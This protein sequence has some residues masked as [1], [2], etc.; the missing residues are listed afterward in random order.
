MRLPSTLAL[1][2]VQPLRSLARNTL[3]SVLAALSIMIGIGAVVC[4]VAI[5]RSGSRRAERALQNLGSDFVWIEA[6]SRAPNGVRTGSHGTT[7][8]TLDDARAIGRDLPL[9][10]RVSP[11]VDGR[12]Q[13][14]YGNRNWNT[15]WRGINQDYFEIRNWNVD[16]GSAFLE[17]DVLRGRSIVLLG[18]TVREKLFGTDDP[19]GKVVR[20]N[21]QLFE[22]TGLLARKGQ[23][24]TGQ[25]QDDNLIVPWTTGVHKLRGRRAEWLDDILCS[26]VSPQAVPPAGSGQESGWGSGSGSNCC[27]VLE[28]CR[29]RSRSRSRVRRFSSIGTSLRAPEPAWPQTP[30]ASP[31][32]RSGARVCRHR[33]AS[34]PPPPRPA[35]RGSALRPTPARPRCRSAR[36]GARGRDGRGAPPRP[37]R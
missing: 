34:S 21:E 24:A 9:I 19:L 17:D 32:K 36:R 29:S 27:S 8:L 22:V 33:P 18:Q 23:S 31:A 20:I 11:N 15:H 1:F 16:S 35:R 26:A 2:L 14:V 25:D 13:I 28:S 37:L 7:S 10:R 30:R 4:V 3:R 5:G 12:A 6:G